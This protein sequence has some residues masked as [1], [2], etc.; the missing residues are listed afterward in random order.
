MRLKRDALLIHYSHASAACRRVLSAPEKAILVYH[1]ITPPEYF[2][3][4]NKN[5]EEASRQGSEQ[6]P[7]YAERAEFAVAHSNYSARELES[8]GFRN[9][10]V[11]PY[12]LWE[13]LYEVEP[14]QS[15]LDQYRGNGWINLLTVGRIAP[16]KRLEDCLFVFDYF[17]KFV[18]RKSRLFIV[19]PW[20]GNEAYMSR[21]QKLVA[22]LGLQDVF[23][24][25]SVPQQTLIGFFE[26]ADAFLC[27]SDHEGFCVPLVEAMRYGVPI[28]AY[29]S[30]AVPETLRGT[31]VLITERSW[32]VVAEAIGLLL[33]D[34]DLRERVISEE[35]QQAAF[36]SSDA[37][38][39]RLRCFLETVKLIEPARQEDSA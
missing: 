7:D 30:T 37:A 38:R 28:F 33:A 8:A 15:L 2:R 5:I 32:P 3:G 22:K 1:G 36:Y 6:L 9:V 27:M 26:L 24:V 18:E 35:R 31:G 29:A 12:V 4:T 11:L 10:V 19:G 25:G 21:L 39:E 16:N 20:A 14:E 23:F 34:D 13:A 17:K